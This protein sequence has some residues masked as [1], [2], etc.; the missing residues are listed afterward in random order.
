MLELGE[1]AMISAAAYAVSSQKSRYLE[2][3]KNIELI[4]R[5]SL[6]GEYKILEQI[7]ETKIR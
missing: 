7:A 1:V 4:Y 5:V 2:T 6:K 3:K